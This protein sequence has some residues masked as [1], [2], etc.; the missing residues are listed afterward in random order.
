MKKTTLFY[1]V[2]R[3]TDW[4]EN[5]LVK[6]GDVINI[7]S[8]RL[9]SDVAC[10]GR[11]LAG[12]KLFLLLDKTLEVFFAH[13]STFTL[14]L[15]MALRAC[16]CSC[17]VMWETESA[18]TRDRLWNMCSTACRQTYTARLTS[19]CWQQATSNKQQATPTTRPSVTAH[20]DQL[21]QSTQCFDRGLGHGP[22]HRHVHVHGGFDN[23]ADAVCIQ[24]T[25]EARENTGATFSY[26]LPC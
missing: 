1:S 10:V 25:L 18:T 20:L 9:Q 26:Q 23:G 19:R 11:Q 21:H 5:F 12:F 15:P 4:L 6:L 22:L 2:L 16:D 13:A 3:R 7:I 24:D 17:R 14:A 8:L